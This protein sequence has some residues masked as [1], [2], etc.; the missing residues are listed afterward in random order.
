[1]PSY[2]VMWTVKGEPFEGHTLDNP[3]VRNTTI[4]TDS[5]A[6]VIEAIEEGGGREEEARVFRIAEMIDVDI[7]EE[8]KQYENELN[9]ARKQFENELND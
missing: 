9:E 6:G 8:R 4:E 2:Y 7:D 1:M 5:P 3:N